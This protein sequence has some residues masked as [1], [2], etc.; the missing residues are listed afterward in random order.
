[1]YAIIKTG[2][3]Q[4]RVETGLKLKIEQIP[5]DIGSELSIDQVLMISDG[6]NVS[7]G[8]PLLSA[9]MTPSE[10]IVGLGAAMRRRLAVFWITLVV[11][12]LGVVAAP[13]AAAADFRPGE[14]P[15]GGDDD[16]DPRL[17][18]VPADA[19]AGGADGQHPDGRPGP[20]G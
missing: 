16:P 6:D 18:P 5:A 7:M 20:L 3:K 8:K 17:R 19:S 10:A 1:M 14:L 15:L 4:Y 2:G 11:T 12:A 9:L 13:P